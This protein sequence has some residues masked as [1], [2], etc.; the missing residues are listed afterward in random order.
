MS[1]RLNPQ[2]MEVALRVVSDANDP[3][4]TIRTA[5]R[6]GVEAGRPG[7]QVA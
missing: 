7:A 3:R 6:Y 5:A 1:F 4:A 2:R